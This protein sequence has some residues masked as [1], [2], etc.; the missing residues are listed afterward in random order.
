MSFCGCNRPLGLPIPRGRLPQR[1][2]AHFRDT[3]SLVAKDQSVPCFNTRSHSIREASSL[4]RP[5]CISRI[6]LWANPEHA[7]A[8]YLLGLVQAQSDHFLDALE[9]IDRAIG[10]KPPNNAAFFCDRGLVLQ[11][12][13][14]FDDAL[15]SF[16]R[17]LSIRPNFP[18]ALNNRGN[19]LME[20]G[21]AADALASYDRA[22]SGFNPDYPDALNNRGN[23][24]RECGASTTHLPVMIALSRSS[25]ALPRL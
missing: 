11:R 13:K 23:A 22:L 4:K 5:P 8:L 21:R 24:L 18:E 16:A 15:K 9:L 19:A 10:N 17:A 12:L 25:P 7:P 1:K 6:S 14:Q 2:S 3:V 20:L